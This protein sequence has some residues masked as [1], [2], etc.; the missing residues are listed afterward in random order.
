MY[1]RRVEEIEQIKGPYDALLKG[2]LIGSFNGLSK[3]DK[4][5]VLDE[6]IK[7]LVE[8]LQTEDETT[9]LFVLLDKMER[10]EDALM[11]VIM[12]VKLMADYYHDSRVYYRY[13]I[14]SEWDRNMDGYGR[15]EEVLNDLE[16]VRREMGEYNGLRVMV[17][18]K[19]LKRLDRPY[20]GSCR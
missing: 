8:D 4:G 15:K 2:L 11:V 9:E 19:I 12:H 13:N 10:Y 16:N 20:V 14:E 6:R 17:V 1:A 3:E 5:R 7:L 18:E